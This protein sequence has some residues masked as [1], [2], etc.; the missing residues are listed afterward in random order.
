MQTFAQLEIYN[1]I[2]LEFN[3]F[4]FSIPLYRHTAKDLK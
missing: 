3:V 2:I 4:N 1:R